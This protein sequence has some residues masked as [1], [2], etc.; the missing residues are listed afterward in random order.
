VSVYD[1]AGSDTFTAV[2][3]EDGLFIVVKRGRIWYPETGVAAD[4]YPVAVTLANTRVSE[5]NVPDLPYIIRGA[6]E[7]RT[8]SQTV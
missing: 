7:R 6:D 8:F 4:V 5:Y 2:G 1:G 3:D